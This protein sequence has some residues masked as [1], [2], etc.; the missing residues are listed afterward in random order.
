MAG[1]LE[2]ELTNNSWG[3]VWKRTCGGLQ[4]SSEE[5]SNLWR[6]EGWNFVI[7]Q[8]AGHIFIM[9]MLVPVNLKY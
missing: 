1:H 2:S 3:I 8:A 7:L 6:T 9:N 4:F 5:I